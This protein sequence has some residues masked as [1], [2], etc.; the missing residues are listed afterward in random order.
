MGRTIIGRGRPAI[1][2]D[3]KMEW[4]RYVKELKG[5]TFKIISLMETLPH[6]VTGGRFTFK[7]IE[8]KIQKTT[9]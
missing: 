3:Y 8:V 5:A 6:P 1:P 9:E 4:D 7:N 2:P